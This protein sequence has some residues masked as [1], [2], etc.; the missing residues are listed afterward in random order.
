MEVRRLR[1]VRQRRLLTQEEL[2]IKAGVGLSTVIRLEQ[3][4]RGRISTVRKIAAALEVTAD[5]LIEER[6][7]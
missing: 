5:E 6:Q 1:A 7:P 2:A 4:E 3:G